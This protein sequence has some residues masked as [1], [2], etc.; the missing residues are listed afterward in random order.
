VARK[1]GLGVL[2]NLG[3]ELLRTPMRAKQKKEKNTR[4]ASKL[5]AAGLS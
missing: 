2:M 5:L 1:R 3:P 4:K